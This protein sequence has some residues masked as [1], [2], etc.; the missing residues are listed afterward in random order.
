MGDGDRRRCR[1]K[2]GAWSRRRFETLARSPAP[3]PP[4]PPPLGAFPPAPASTTSPR[5]ATLTFCSVFLH[6]P[7]R[8]FLSPSA[9]PR[10]SPLLPPSRLVP[11]PL[12]S[13][14]P[15]SPSPLIPIRVGTRGSSPR[16][17]K[18]SNS[19]TGD[20]GDCARVAKSRASGC[21]YERRLA[22]LSRRG[23]RGPETSVSVVAATAAPHLEERFVHAHAQRDQHD[24]GDDRGEGKEH[25]AVNDVRDVSPV[26]RHIS[27]VVP[28]IK[29]EDL[30]PGLR[31]REKRRE[32]RGR[33]RVGGG[34]GG[35]GRWRECGGRRTGV[36]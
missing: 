30:V 28:A 24:Q 5:S 13:S 20:R 14:S 27:V 16:Q 2:G 19:Q 3:S 11:P 4:L 18:L 31:R 12:P 22:G 15:S 26:T 8:A 21:R 6:S 25:A 17:S 10:M 34:G 36:A 33:D 9:H 23:R 29:V 1:G 7:E 32:R 35:C